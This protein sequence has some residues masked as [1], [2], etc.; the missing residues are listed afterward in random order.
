MFASCFLILIIL[1]GQTLNFYSTSLF[2]LINDY[3]GWY[4]Y[5]FIFSISYLIS[6]ESSS[7]SLSV[8]LNFIT[9]AFY[10]FPPV[11]SMT[12]SNLLVY[13]NTFVIWDINSLRV[14]IMI[15]FSYRN[16]LILVLKTLLWMLIF[17]I[18]ESIQC[19]KFDDQLCHFA[20]FSV[21][22]T[23]MIIFLLYLNLCLVI[24]LYFILLNYISLY[25]CPRLHYMKDQKHQFLLWIIFAN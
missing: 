12:T 1:V 21:C 11:L 23:L 9:L 8:V 24:L 13:Q 5:I 14:F 15:L 7:W 20:T 2:I 22:W 4:C 18:R 16:Y 25:W 10:L 6:N 19:V 17:L 3:Y